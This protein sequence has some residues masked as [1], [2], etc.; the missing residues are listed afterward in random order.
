M[1]TV[2]RYFYKAKDI[3]EKVVRSSKPPRNAQLALLQLYHDQIGKEPSDRVNAGYVHA[4]EKFLER[5]IKN[6][7]CFTDLEPHLNMITF[8]EILHLVKSCKIPEG[9]P[10]KDGQVRTGLE[11]R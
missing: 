6:N 4:C 2:R 3:I 7:S 10:E 5:N 11:L 1:F 9:F 8:T